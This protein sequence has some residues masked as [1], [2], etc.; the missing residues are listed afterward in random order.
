MYILY[1]GNCQVD[2]L[3]N[4][5]I[6]DCRRCIPCWLTDITE[7]DFLKVLHESDVVVTQPIAS[8]YRG[9]YYL[10]TEYI[11]KN[12]KPRTK[13][14]IFPS[15]HFEFYYPDLIYKLTSDG[16]IIR[17]PSDYHYSSI[18]KHYKKGT[19]Y[20]LEHVVNNA[21]YKSQK[22]LYTLAENSINELSRREELLKKYV[23]INQKVSII[24]CSEYIRTH[25]R[26]KFLFYS[27]NHPTPY[28]LQYIAECIKD[29]LCTGIIDYKY[30]YLKNNERGILYA[31]I[32]KCVNFDTCIHLPRLNKYNIE[33]IKEV[34]DKYIECYTI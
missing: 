25:Y 4:I 11:I 30:D 13:I 6:T 21:E 28:I 14:I 23:G 20:I 27:M 34:V 15:L 10:S 2:S 9:K 3:M 19:D 26:E 24:T 32:Q 5:L 1:Y 31:C 17:E 33:A 29:M 12:C 7:I 16:D 8:D 22:E 18:V